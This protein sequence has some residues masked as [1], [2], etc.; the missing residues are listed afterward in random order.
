MNKTLT[1]FNLK[2]NYGLIIKI[3]CRFAYCHFA[4]WYFAYDGFPN[5]Q[6]A[7]YRFDYCHFAYNFSLSTAI[8][9]DQPLLLT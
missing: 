1:K 6:F 7:Y 3:P 2:G 9:P 8:L 5:S 4:Q